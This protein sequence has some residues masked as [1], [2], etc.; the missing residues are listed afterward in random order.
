MIPVK[1][2]KIVILG[3]VL[4][5]WSTVYEMFM[6]FIELTL[7]GRQRSQSDD[8]CPLDIRPK[9]LQMGQVVF[10]CSILYC[11]LITM[12]KLYYVNHSH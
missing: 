7:D 2:T 11:E 4:N 8:I 9:G 12:N 1:Q 6:V 3:V 10:K 5:F